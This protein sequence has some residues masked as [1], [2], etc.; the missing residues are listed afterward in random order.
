MFHCNGWGYPW[1]IAALAGTMVCCRNVA[2]KDIYDLIADHKI[3]HFSGAP[4]VLNLIA[5]AADNEKREI[6]HK[7]HVITAGAAS[8]FYSRENGE[9]RLRSDARLWLNRNIRTCSPMCMEQGLGQF[10][11]WKKSRNQSAP[12]SPISDDGRN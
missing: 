7:V 2:A 3:T 10:A 8:K 12:G 1:T 6:D 11:C 5:N 9:A 4:I